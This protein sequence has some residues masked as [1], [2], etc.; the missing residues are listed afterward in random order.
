MNRIALAVAVLGLST[1]AALAATPYNS[2]AANQP[3]Q[4]QQQMQQSSDQMGMA[5]RSDWRANQET[6]ALNLLEAQGFTSFTDF[7]PAGHDQYAANVMRRGH[8]TTVW[9][10]PQDGQITR[11]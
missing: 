10:N 6:K 2:T 3:A 11:G 4:N 5:Q 1:G 8:D 7:R 9:V